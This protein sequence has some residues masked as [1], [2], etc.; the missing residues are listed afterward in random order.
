MPD[1]LND[2]DV[3]SL[4]AEYVLGTLDANERTRANVLLDVDHGFR[5]KVRAW[6]A[7]LGELHLMVEPVEPD[8]HIQQRITVRLGPAMPVSVAPVQTD[9][10]QI[11]EAPAVQPD[12]PVETPPTPTPAASVEDDPVA[13]LERALEQMRAHERS[14][15]AVPVDPLPEMAPIVEPKVETPSQA[16]R[17][18][19]PESITR[20]PSV[21]PLEFRP[22]ISETQ[23]A[24]GPPE[25][26]ERRV[27][28][29]EYRGSDEETPVRTGGSSASG[30]RFV[31]MAMTLVAAMLAGLIS[32]WR[33]APDRLPPRLRPTAVLHLPD[34]PE[35]PQKKVAPPGSE[36]DE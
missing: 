29:Q 8:V 24:D 11:D 3:D 27:V 16:T 10:G 14:T 9:I 13:E 32:A 35:L 12:V 19:A 4:A 21:P 2:E 25:P 33:Y 15:V 34:R 18:S 23:P 7:R 31:A 26:E 1:G 36:F 30:W 6:E 17:T 22:L 5:A 20:G 28:I